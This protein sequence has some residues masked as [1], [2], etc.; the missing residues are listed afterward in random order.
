MPNAQFHYLIMCHSTEP[1]NFEIVK[2]LVNPSIGELTDLEHI[3]AY[4]NAGLKIC[5]DGFTMSDTI[6]NFAKFYFLAS[7]TTFLITRPS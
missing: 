2:H 4:Q 7:I 3:T 1:E 6:N 5:A